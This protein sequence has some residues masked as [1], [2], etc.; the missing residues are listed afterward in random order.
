MIP[1]EIT[2]LE[3]LG[4]ERDDHVALWEN[5]DEKDENI[6]ERQEEDGLVIGD[7]NVGHGIMYCGGRETYLEI[8]EDCCEQERDYRR[9]LENL[10]DKKDWK[11]YTIK[12]HGLKS[13]MK[14][15]GADRLSDLAKTIE[16]A[17]KQRD[18]AYITGHHGELLMEYHRVIEE[19]AQCPYLSLDLAQEKEDFAVNEDLAGMPELSEE[20]FDRLLYSLEEAVYAF[21]SVQMLS[22][23]SEM[24]EYQ[25]CGASLKKK[26]L[27]VRKKIEM[28]DYMSAVDTV[29]GIRKDMKNQGEGGTADA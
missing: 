13:T 17:G 20:E 4:Q 12:V 25:Y 18:V 7:L 5:R 28:A 19:I 27:P 21:D 23:L 9:E 14:S 24:Q 16:L 8:L 15:I 26:L 6:K 1:D 22:V 3:L 11:N 10:Y 2:E 29:S